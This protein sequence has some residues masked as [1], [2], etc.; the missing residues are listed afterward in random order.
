MNEILA[1]SGHSA[2]M[3]HAAD[4]L[5]HPAAVAGLAVVGGFVGLHF[6]AGKP[7]FRDQKFWYVTQIFLALVASYFAVYL[8]FWVVAAAAGA[9]GVR[10]KKAGQVVPGA[11]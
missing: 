3:N 2:W 11:S 9:V 5:R 10:A 1:A 4:I 6:R 8:P 7:R